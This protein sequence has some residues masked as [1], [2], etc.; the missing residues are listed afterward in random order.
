MDFSKTLSAGRSTVWCAR[1]V[2]PR[3]DSCCR[4]GMQ[5]GGARRLVHPSRS[6]S[7]RQSARLWPTG[8]AAR[9]TWWLGRPAPDPPR[10]GPGPRGGVAL[11]PSHAV[12]GGPPAVR[13]TREA[14]QGGGSA[15]ATASGA[16]AAVDGRVAGPANVVPE[17]ELTHEEA[18]QLIVKPKVKKK[19]K[20]V[21]YLRLDF[22]L[23]TKTYLKQNI[24]QNRR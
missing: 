18:L 4:C 14:L 2:H 11:L 13:L 16:V 9:P 10:S 21:N 1:R 8:T 15:A 12:A 6:S 7:S 5:V 23:R 22:L 20:S 3:I 19:K 24:H 17:L